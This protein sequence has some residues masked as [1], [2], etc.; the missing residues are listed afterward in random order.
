MNKRKVLQGIPI[1]ILVIIVIYTGFTGILMKKFFSLNIYAGIIS[2]TICFVLY[3]TK[4][5]WFKYL[6]FIAL[7]IGSFNILHF[8]FKEVTISFSLGLFKFLNIETIDIQLLSFS[9]L[10]LFAIINRKRI[11]ELIKGFIYVPDE[12]NLKDEEA[13]IE[14]FKNKYLTMSKSELKNIV[15]NK[16]SYTFEAVKAAQRLLETKYA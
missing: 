7:I 5:R 11:R 16:E 13:R 12:E 2:I 1:F 9:I 8:T 10:L 14:S 6:F 4:Y 15:D 3:F